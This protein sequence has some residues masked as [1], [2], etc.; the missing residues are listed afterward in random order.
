MNFIDKWLEPFAT[1]VETMLIVHQYK[2]ELQNIVST[3]AFPN[4]KFLDD[5]VSYGTFEYDSEYED[6]NH[7]DYYECKVC[8]N[9][10]VKIIDCIECLLNH[11]IAQ[12]TDKTC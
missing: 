2:I 12:E 4:H 7:E 10:Y 9:D 8:S 11:W 3:M 6:T 5:P 1:Y